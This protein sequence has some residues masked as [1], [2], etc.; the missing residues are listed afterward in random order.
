MQCCDIHI[1]DKLQ[2]TVKVRPFKNQVVLF[3]PKMQGF[4]AISDPMAGWKMYRKYLV[5]Q[6][7][8]VHSADITRVQLL[9]KPLESLWRISM[10][11]R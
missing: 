3:F 8:S 2:I 10:H 6:S 9:E 5:D 4:M 11:N 1:T 7:Y